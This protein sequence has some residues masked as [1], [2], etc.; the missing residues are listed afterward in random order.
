MQKIKVGFN[1]NCEDPL[2][3][4]RQ[5]EKQLV[6]S[7]KNGVFSP[8]ERL[9]NER[10]LASETGLSRVTVAK[11]YTE[12][13]RHGLVVRTPKRGTFVA[14]PSLK[15][16]ESKLITL[17]VRG[18][19]QDSLHLS[20]IAN[21][22]INGFKDEVTARGYNVGLSFE[23]DY[24]KWQDVAADSC[25]TA[26][27]SVK[28]PEINISE[29]PTVYMMGWF[30]GTPQ[31]DWVH[32]DSETGGRLAAEHLLELGHEN[33]ACYASHFWHSGVDFRLKGFR[34]TI[35]R[36][37]IEINEN[38]FVSRDKSMTLT[39]MAEIFK[40]ENRPTAVFCMGD[41]DGIKVMNAALDFG[42]KV[43][44]DIS[45]IS[46][47]GTSLCELC[48]PAMTSIFADRYTTGKR[49]ADCLIS[50]IENNDQGPAREII[51]PV[52]LKVRGSTG[53]VK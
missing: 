45:I 39:D 41:H 44:E 29:I 15:K 13:K 43:P 14:E 51:T 33:F 31:V 53:L 28:Y 6:S 18:G 19:G 30:D 24:N 46:F 34:E 4:F 20:E 8:G 2:P 38:F 35:E 17:F 32:N 37:D 7:I 36:R 40:S 12:L 9:P 16:T 21:N 50:R 3:P 10:C 22:Y 47:D 49:A 25:G 27:F 52:Y 23:H 5:L 11:A 48:R 42:L 1:I 26:V